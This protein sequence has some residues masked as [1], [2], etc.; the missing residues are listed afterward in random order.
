MP[1]VNTKAVGSLAAV[2]LLPPNA[3][4]TTTPSRQS[5]PPH[6]MT[7]IDMVSGRMHDIDGV[8]RVT[9]DTLGTG[10][11]ASVRITARGWS[12]SLHPVRLQLRVQDDVTRTVEEV[13]MGILKGLA[14]A[15][16]RQRGRAASAKRLTGRV[17]PL[18]IG[19][20]V[21]L[22]HMHV[23]ASLD[24]LCRTAGY[25][26]ADQLPAVVRRIHELASDHDGGLEHRVA[27]GF[28]AEHPG[29]RGG[30]TIREAGL[31]IPCDATGDRPSFIYDGAVLTIYAPPVPETM[32]AMMPGRPLR[33]LVML[34]PSLDDRIVGTIGQQHVDKQHI[35]ITLKRDLV[36]FRSLRT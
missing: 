4:V 32:A 26:L 19:Y 29:S 15:L 34:H 5:L 30:E 16:D 23:D 24:G 18:D 27:V 8:S 21:D 35:T 13:A 14:P 7:V 1:P 2:T 12:P 33:D 20:G 9:V 22:Q 28:V 11:T 36:P 25:A 6:M 10:T 3:A 17:E 31:M